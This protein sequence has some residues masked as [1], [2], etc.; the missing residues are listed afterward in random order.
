MASRYPIPPLPLAIEYYRLQIQYKLY[1]FHYFP[2]FQCVNII[3]ESTDLWSTTLPLTLGRL[4]FQAINVQ[5]PVAKLVVISDFTNWISAPCMLARPGGVESSSPS[6]KFRFN[7]LKNAVTRL[8]RDNRDSVTL[9]WHSWLILVTWHALVTR[10]EETFYRL[11]KLCLV[12]SA[13][14]PAYK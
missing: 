2:H 13:G 9:L 4:Q 12:S 11:V 6:W 5:W 8:H 10:G 3:S 14:A 1:K 7:W